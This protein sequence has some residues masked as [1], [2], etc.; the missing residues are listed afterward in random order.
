[1]YAVK[2]LFCDDEKSSRRP[3]VGQRVF[4]VSTKQHIPHGTKEKLANKKNYD[5]GSIS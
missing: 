3:K 2:T 1:M 4:T 5:S